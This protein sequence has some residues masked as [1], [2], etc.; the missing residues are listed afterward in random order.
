[1]TTAQRAWQV[2]VVAPDTLVIVGTPMDIPELVLAV[3]HAHDADKIS[4]GKSTLVI[5]KTK[6]FP[7]SDFRTSFHEYFAD[8]RLSIDEIFPVICKFEEG[9]G[10]VVKY[11]GDK[12]K[13]PLGSVV[14]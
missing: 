6:G 10:Y 1:M 7:L 4:K 11:T 8:L 3:K 14:A 2:D 5:L 12:Q 9:R 13:Y